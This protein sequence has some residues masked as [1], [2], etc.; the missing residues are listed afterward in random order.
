MV[1]SVTRYP[2][3]ARQRAI[4]ANAGSNPAIN[5]GRSPTPECLGPADVLPLHSLLAV[6]TA[7]TNAAQQLLIVKPS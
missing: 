6:F 2:K 5:R 1:S 4:V 7:R 3:P